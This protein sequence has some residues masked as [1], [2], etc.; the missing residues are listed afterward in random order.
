V[1]NGPLSKKRG[2]LI[3]HAL[4]RLRNAESDVVINELLR[5][6]HRKNSRLQKQL[7]RGVDDPGSLQA[8]LNFLVKTPKSAQQ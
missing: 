5:E 8:M 2:E 6:L 3:A 7:G 1:Y 4:P